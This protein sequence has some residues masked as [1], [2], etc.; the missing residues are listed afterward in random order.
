MRPKKLKKGKKNSIPDRMIALRQLLEGLVAINIEFLKRHEKVSGK[1]YPSIY[2]VAP[3]YRGPAD[4]GT[5]QDISSVI[6]N[7]GGDVCDL[8]CWRIAELRSQGYEDVSPFIQ[9]TYTDDG[10]TLTEVR[11]RIKNVIEDTA[12]LLTDGS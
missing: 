7:G 5:W 4:F 3:K 12:S 2:D 6:K 1:T 8:V 10:L 9:M 11:V